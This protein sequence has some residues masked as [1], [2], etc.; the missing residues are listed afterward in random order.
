ML[1]QHLA[2]IA[3]DDQQGRIIQIQRFELVDYLPDAVVGIGE[4]LSIGQFEDFFL[5]IRV[6][7]CAGVIGETDR[8]SGCD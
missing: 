4:L 1:A 3:H 6:C 8:F 5:F 2:V 7:G